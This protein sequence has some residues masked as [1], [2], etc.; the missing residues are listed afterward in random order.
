M[1]LFDEK[2]NFIDVLVPLIPI[3]EVEILDE[4]H[5]I[6]MRRS[7]SN[8]ANFGEMSESTSRAGRLDRVL[9]GDIKR[10]GEPQDI[11]EAVA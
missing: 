1:D 8:V 9:S 2:G 3:E 7:A 6:A 5:T 11:A 4:W 10:R